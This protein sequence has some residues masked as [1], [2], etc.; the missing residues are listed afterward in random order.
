M[1]QFIDVRMA[2]ARRAH[3][4]AR[5]LMSPQG[6]TQH[7]D[8]R[9][10]GSRGQALSRQRGMFTG[11]SQVSIVLPRSKTVTVDPLMP[12]SF[13][14]HRARAVPIRSHRRSARRS[15]TVLF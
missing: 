5:G 9:M 13:G 3:D 1:F 6:I 4:D 15:S 8:L 14:R 12:R 11:V 2:P 10:E 7:D